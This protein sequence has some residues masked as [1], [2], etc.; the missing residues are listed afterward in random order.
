VHDTDVAKVDL[1]VTLLQWL[2]MYV[3]SIYS[4]CFIYFRHML[5]VFLSRCCI[6]CSGFMLQVF[7]GQA[8][9]Q[10]SRVYMCFIFIQGP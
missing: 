3:A 6:Y 10:V 9:T 1:D 5:Q 7:R 8:Q 2:Y 4:E